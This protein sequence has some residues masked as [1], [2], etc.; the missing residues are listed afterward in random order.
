[1]FTVTYILQNWSQYFLKLRLNS[2]AYSLLGNSI[3]LPTIQLLANI[4]SLNS[5]LLYGG[6]V[7]YGNK[8][9]Y[10]GLPIISHWPDLST[11]LDLLSTISFQSY[12]YV[13]CIQLLCRFKI[14]ICQVC[15]KTH[16]NCLLSH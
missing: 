14:Q 13:Q 10:S 7:F 8:C 4:Y 12:I 16:I 2:M 9:F 5:Y 1:M 15:H 11:F 6:F 3:L